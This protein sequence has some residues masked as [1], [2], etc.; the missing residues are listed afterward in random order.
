MGRREDI[1]ANIA[2]LK[3][4]RT[5]I[6]NSAGLEEGIED[7]RR[8]QSLVNRKSR[9]ITR[10]TKQ[11]ES[12]DTAKPAP[13][14]AADAN[15]GAVAQ[16]A[17]RR[18]QE[19]ERR[20]SIR[21]MADPTTAAFSGAAEDVRLQQAATTA[22]K[23]PVDAKLD[24]DGNI[25]TTGLADNTVVKSGDRYFRYDVEIDGTT[26]VFFNPNTDSFV[27]ENYSTPEG[28][29][30]IKSRML[31][32]AETLRK[33]AIA[34]GD[35]DA[36][37][38]QR[39][40]QEAIDAV[41]T[42]QLRD[43]ERDKA[44]AEL[45]KKYKSVF[46]AADDAQVKSVQEAQAAAMADQEAKFEEDRDKFGLAL[47]QAVADL[48]KRQNVEVEEGR[49][50]SSPETQQQQD[51]GDYQTYSE[52]YDAY[53][54]TVKE[55]MDALP[56][57]EDT[58]ERIRVIQMNAAREAGLVSMAEAPRMG[59]IGPKM[60][61]EDFKHRRNMRRGYRDRNSRAKISA[62]HAMQLAMEELR[63]LDEGPLSEE[64]YYDFLESM[65]NADL[66]RGYGLRRRAE[67]LYLS[68][69]NDFQMRR[70]TL[71]QVVADMRGRIAHIDML[72]SYAGGGGEFELRNYDVAATTQRLQSAGLPVTFEDVKQAMAKA[73]AESN[74]QAIAEAR[75]R[76]RQDEATKQ[77]IRGYSKRPLN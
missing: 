50:A 12:V 67:N 51:T 3:R 47:E 75:L 11:L 39:E 43:E 16:A 38:K 21:K 27:A 1:E 32:S 72:E 8:N 73:A 60:T 63:L 15:R 36:L 40:I 33:N 58:D 37:A 5:A 19:R 10:L 24:K 22:P 14:N 64:R 13:A 77:R 44:F 2:R 41:N 52:Q 9:S 31:S 30:L 69:T 66:D 68:L 23:L 48:R 17:E 56:A 35:P 61:F 76:V 29:R 49:R 70:H 20:Q 42:S 74:N 34:S 25:I 26:E 6:E 4:E 59:N 7:Y 54:K 28:L 45:Y 65:M 57:G 18:R 46:Q 71:S 55:K 62:E 53:A